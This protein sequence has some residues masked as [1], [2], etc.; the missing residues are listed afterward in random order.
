[1]IKIANEHDDQDCLSQSFLNLGLSQSNWKPNSNVNN[2]SLQFLFFFFKK[3][4]YS[5]QIINKSM[6]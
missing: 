2:R 4:S 6:I 5:I 1:M 3:E